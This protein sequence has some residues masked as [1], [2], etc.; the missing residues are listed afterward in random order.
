MK[1]N[2]EIT[3]VTENPKWGWLWRSRGSVLGHPA[4]WKRTV[5]Y[6]FW[7]DF[8]S[9]L[10]SLSIPSLEGTA[11]G[12]QSTPLWSHVTGGLVSFNEKWS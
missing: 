12:I 9:P 6:P 1:G 10:A 2:V 3:P 11:L 4:S 8:L 7:W 5:A